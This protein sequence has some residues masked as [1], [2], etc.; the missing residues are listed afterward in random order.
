VRGEPETTVRGALH[1]HANIF[2]AG[3]ERSD[4]GASLCVKYHLA[5]CD[6]IMNFIY[7]TTECSIKHGSGI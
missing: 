4:H 2:E 3:I 1:G 6:E 5:C 7:N